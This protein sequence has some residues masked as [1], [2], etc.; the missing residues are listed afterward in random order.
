MSWC[1]IYRC[2]VQSGLVIV[3][4]GCWWADVTCTGV[5]YSQV[6]SLSH[7]AVDGLMSHVQVWRT[8][9]SRHC[10]TWLL[11]GWCYMYRCDVQ[12]NSCVELPVVS[13]L[14]HLAGL[15]SVK[16]QANLSV[17]DL[18]FGLFMRFLFSYFNFYYIFVTLPADLLDDDCSLS[19][20]LLSFINYFFWW[21]Q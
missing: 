20:C 5:T 4:P 16:L 13:S 2:E 6:S 12:S 14:S 21:L 9:R 3:T 18:F 7:L 19:F 11:M 15:T 1:H 17:S 8:V 10:H